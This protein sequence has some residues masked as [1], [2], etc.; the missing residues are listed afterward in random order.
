MRRI[1]PP[2]AIPMISVEAWRRAQIKATLALC[3]KNNP[4]TTRLIECVPPSDAKLQLI[5]IAKGEIETSI[6]ALVEGL[7]E[8]GGY[9]N[10]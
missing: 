10:A 1:I 7:I 3:F 9:L 8:A 5:L 6:D 2:P 4:A